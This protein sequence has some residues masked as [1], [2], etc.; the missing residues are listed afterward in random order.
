MRDVC[1]RNKWSEGTRLEEREG[2]GRV[3]KGKEMAVKLNVEFPNI[4]R[5]RSFPAS[6][7][8]IQCGMFSCLFHMDR[9]AVQIIHIVR[10]RCTSDEEKRK[11]EI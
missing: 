10:G 5:H 11:Q 4:S 6:L 2:D 1:T 7:Q 9:S 3:K 8:R